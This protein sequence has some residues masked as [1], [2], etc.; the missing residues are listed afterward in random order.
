LA[1]LSTAIGARIDC[2]SARPQSGNSAAGGT[3]MPAQ[4]WPAEF[5]DVFV[6]GRLTPRPTAARRCATISTRCG[7]ASA[8]D[9]GLARE[10]AQ[11]A[12]A[13]E[14][15]FPLSWRPFSPERRGGPPAA[16]AA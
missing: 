1:V 12:I 7:A 10:S 6:N 11:L 15:T 4:S 16:G 9:G 14:A 8:H 5:A 3:G 13:D 2:I